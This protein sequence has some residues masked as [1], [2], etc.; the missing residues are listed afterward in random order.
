MKRVLK[1]L[2]ALA[3]T[4]L[5]AFAG[6]FIA[7]RLTQRAYEK[8][9]VSTET[10]PY[11]TG[12]PAFLYSHADILVT[13]CMLLFALCAALFLRDL[14]AHEKTRFSPKLLLLLPA[15]AAVGYMSVNLLAELDEIRFMPELSRGSVGEY[16]CMALF[17]LLQ[18]LLIRDCVGLSLGDTLGE[19]TSCAVSAL[20][21]AALL[22][23]VYGS[24][25]P[26]LLLNGLLFGFSAQK[27]YFVRRS[28]LPESFL[29]FG[30]TAAH[31]LLSGYPDGGAYYVSDS[32][33]A[34]G[35][36]GITGSLLLTV[37]LAAALV[38]LLRKRRNSNG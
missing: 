19:W 7:L 3:G 37:Y 15:A 28:V 11:L 2:S 32:V 23:F 18:A 20:L 14:N 25:S 33:L 36:R 21:Q 24:F 27:L 22:A 4:A 29:A 35:A 17:C 34:G 38:L 9:N 30:F 12:I 13:L 10:V 1:A 6:R 31:K 5:A 8:L 26:V 16:L